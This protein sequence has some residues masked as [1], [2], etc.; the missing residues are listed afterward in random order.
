MSEVH[1][2]VRPE[3]R[4]G[5]VRARGLR[6]CLATAVVPLCLVLAAPLGAGELS[7][8]R[9]GAEQPSPLRSIAPERPVQSGR[10]LRQ[11]EWAALLVEALDLTRALPEGHT[12]EDLFSILCPDAAELRLAAGG[13]SV[14]ARQPFRVAIDTPHPGAPGRP[15][16]IDVNVPATAIYALVVEGAGRQ[17]WYVNRQRIARLDPSPLGADAAP[18]LLPLP[19]GSHQLV[20]NLTPG[21]RVDHVELT[22]HRAVCV[23]PAD[24]WSADEPLTFGAKAR[25]MVRALGLDARLP[26]DGEAIVI[27]AE[28]YDEALGG[29]ARTSARVEPSAPSAGEWVVAEHGETELTYRVRLDEPGVYGLLA[30]LHGRE[31]QLWSIDNRYRV[32]VRPGPEAD[33]FAWTEVATLPLS[34]GE[35]VFRARMP[36]GSGIDVVRLARRRASDADYL[37]VLEAAGFREG[38]VD[39]RVTLADAQRNLGHPTFRVLANDFLTRI[40]GGSADDFALIEH[41][42]GRLYTRPLSPLLPADL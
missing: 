10:T 30:R 21:A 24:G 36:R 12:A 3:S 5:G 29:A 8:I 19:R 18:A 33:A 31:R 1:R 39:A 4:S 38:P 37:G 35:H 25:S 11:E 15:I 16:R 34:I 41:D 13:R 28:R 27:E 20:A 17:S 32:M 6:G 9:V 26:V 14:P 2:Q 7:P 40:S 23:A 42:L 22:A